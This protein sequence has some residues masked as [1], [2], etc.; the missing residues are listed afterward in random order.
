MI[1]QVGWHQPFSPMSSP[2]ATGGPHGRW[3]L[4]GCRTGGSSHFCSKP[5]LPEFGQIWAQKNRIL[6]GGSKHQVKAVLTWVTNP[7][8]RLYGLVDAFCWERVT[9]QCGHLPVSFVGFFQPSY[10]F[11]L[12]PLFRGLYIHLQQVS[13]RLPCIYH[14]HPGWQDC[15]LTGKSWGPW[16]FEPKFL[17]F[18]PANQMCF[19]WGAGKGFQ[20]QLSSFSVKTRVGCE[21]YRGCFILPNYMG[22][23][24]WLIYI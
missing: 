6:Q 8:Y 1:L 17:T 13:G 4:S 24:I 16:G 2:F 5:L 14:P 3:T 19:V 20:Y 15:H 22:I 10:P 23:C 11:S 12:R 21:R 7:T 18:Y 9:L